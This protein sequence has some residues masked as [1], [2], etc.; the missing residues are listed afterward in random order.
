MSSLAEVKIA[1]HNKTQTDAD[2]KVYWLVLQLPVDHGGFKQRRKEQERSSRKTVHLRINNV[3]STTVVSV[4]FGQDF[5][6][7]LQK[8]YTYKYENVYAEV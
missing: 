5:Y 1:R 2:L 3:T 7:S 4:T 6:T 8:N